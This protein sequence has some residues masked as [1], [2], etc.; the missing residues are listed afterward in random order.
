[1]I[2]TGRPAPLG[3]TPDKDGTNFAI[4]SEVAQHVE[5]CLFDAQGLSLIHI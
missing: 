1:M 4:Y 2:E 5:L 3:A